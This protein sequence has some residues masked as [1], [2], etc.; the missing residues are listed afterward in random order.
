MHHRLMNLAPI[1]GNYLRRLFR[2]EGRALFRQ[3]AIRTTI[4]KMIEI[5]RMRLAMTIGHRDHN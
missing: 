5:E 3:N 2:F 4:A 1:A